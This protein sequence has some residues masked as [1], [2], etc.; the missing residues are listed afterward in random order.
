[1]TTWV[2]SLSALVLLTS[3]ASCATTC[4]EIDAHRTGFEQRV[5]SEDGA[6][7]RLT[8][9]WALLDGLVARELAR[10]PPIDVALP[11]R[12]LGS[13]LSLSVILDSVRLSA[14]PPGR[15]GAMVTISLRD[16]VLRLATFSFDTTVPLR[17]SK[18]PEG[19]SLTLTLMPRDVGAM[20]AK[21][22]QDGHRAMGDWIRKQLPPVAR[23]LATDTVVAALADELL[24]L[25][26]REVWPRIKD[27]VLGREALFETAI[28]LP[29]LHVSSFSASSRPDA[30]VVSITSGFPDATTLPPGDEKVDHGRVVLRM[31][32]GTVAGLVNQGISLGLVPG[33]FSESGKVDADG[34]W[35]M[36]MGWAPG[37][38]P[39]RLHLWR[40]AGRC[41]RAEIGADV[42]LSLRGDSISVDVH[43]GRYLDVEG[44][45]FAAMLAWL[46]NTF[47]KA[48]GTS[49]EVDSLL[50]F[51]AGHARFVRTHL[52]S[53]LLVE[54]ELLL[55]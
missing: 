29:D 21:S 46:D 26:A 49:L 53:D 22:S 12:E 40:T 27:E 36:R 8:L 34:P 23:R 16:G 5:R 41:Q 44:P 35:T 25:F 50:H 52:G 7:A 32:G 14:A 28:G 38:R 24:G 3:S 17:L 31:S 10:R 39:V 15:V 18:S 1:M 45:P 13:T 37:Q 19:T 54:L 6:D 30:L 33:R 20:H 2:M 55:N 42:S 4:P 9:P 43:D 11:L 47:G 48:L 51:G